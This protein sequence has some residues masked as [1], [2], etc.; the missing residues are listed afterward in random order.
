MEEMSYKLAYAC[1]CVLVQS[2]STIGS[3]DFSD[4]LH[5]RLNL[6]NLKRDGG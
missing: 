1:V 3:L 5:A 6:L 2:F 4:F